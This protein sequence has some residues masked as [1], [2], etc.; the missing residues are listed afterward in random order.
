MPGTCGARSSPS[1][2][3]LNREPAVG[4]HIYARDVYAIDFVE[5][6][7]S[8]ASTSGQF[9]AR[10]FG[11]TTTPCGPDYADVAGAGHGTVV[12]VGTFD[13]VHRGH[14]RVVNGH[15]RA[16]FIRINGSKCADS[17]D[18]RG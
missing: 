13:G 8:A 11:W 9:F 3:V 16:T 17:S 5:F 12:T 15:R 18:R 10:A 2:L 4:G 7:S 1:A 6:P 14:Q